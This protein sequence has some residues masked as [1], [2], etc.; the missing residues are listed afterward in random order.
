[1]QAD[2]PHLKDLISHAVQDAGVLGNEQD[3]LQTQQSSNKSQIDGCS[4]NTKEQ[5]LQAA[6]AGNHTVDTHSS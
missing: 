3:L 1:M 4:M 2:R 6:S 5:R